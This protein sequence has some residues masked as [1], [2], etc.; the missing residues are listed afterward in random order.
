MI[1]STT[2]R[3]RPSLSPAYAFPLVVMSGICLAAMSW[4]CGNEGL[5]VPDGTATD[6]NVEEI[7]VPGETSSDYGA[8]LAR[9]EDEGSENYRYEFRWICYC[10]RRDWVEVTVR[11]DS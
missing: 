6:D 2:R 5:L 4:G 3:A 7:V 11:E 8:S 1:S 10:T 9:W